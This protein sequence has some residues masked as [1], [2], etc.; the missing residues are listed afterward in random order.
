MP[1]TMT[2]AELLSAYRAAADRTDDLSD[3][4]KQN[5]AAKEVHFYYKKLRDS[6]EGRAGI[7]RLM[8]D[9]S[10]HVRGWAAAHSLQWVPDQARKVLESLRDEDTFPYSFDALITLEEFEKGRLSFDY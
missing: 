5:N 7:I 8:V 9:P 4:S 2:L 6:E 10:P 1:H 3:S